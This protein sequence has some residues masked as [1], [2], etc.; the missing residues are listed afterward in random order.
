MSDIDLKIRSRDIGTLLKMIKNSNPDI[1]LAVIQK[2]YL[3]AN[4]AHEGQQRLSGEPYIVHPLEVGIILAG[5]KLDTDTI[6][7]ALLH[8]TVEDTGTTLDMI[9]KAFGEEV[10]R[11]VDS[12]TKI[13]S[14]KSRTKATAQ[15]ATLRKMLIA[16][17]KDIRVIII[18]LAD[19]LHNMRTIMFQP[20]ETQ[21]RVAKETLD[22]YAPLARRLGMSK[23]SSELEDLAFRVLDP[24]AYNEIRNNIAQRDT[25]LEE[26]LENVRMILGERLAALNI[27][28]RITGRAKHYYSIHKKIQEQEKSFEEIYDIRA[29]RIITEEIRDCYGVLGVVHTLWSPI[30]KRFKDYIAVPKSNMYQSLHTTVIGPDGHRLEVQIRTEKMHATAEMGIAAHWLYKEDPSVIRKDSRNLTFLKDITEWQTDVQD[31]REFMKSL[32]M[33]LY[34]NEIFVFSPKGKIIKL[35]KG[36][37]PIDFAYSIH[38]EIGHSTIGAKVNSQIVPLKAKLKS[39]DIVEIMTSKKGHPSES[40]LKLAIS[41]GARNRIRQWLRRQLESET[42]TDEEQEKPKDEKQPAAPAQGDDQIRLKSTPRKRQ[43]QAGITING[44]TNILIRLSQC[45]Q[46]IPGDDVVGFITRGRGIT[47]HKRNCPSL[48]RLN[49]EQERFVNI[50][51]EGSPDTFYPVKVAVEGIDRPNLLKDVADEIALAKTNIV[52]VEARVEKADHAVFRFILE[53]RSNDHLK[54]II[55]RL[56]NIKNITNVYKLNEKV[57]LK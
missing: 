7:A 18:K 54:D 46:P 36:A 23:I 55:A 42:K 32:K 34:D 37:T 24:D 49:H 31:T 43:K 38:T 53:V 22:I 45:C 41:P 19:K 11:L 8:D 5:F 50:K 20:P 14:I 21:T 39:G 25:E 16:T 56:K 26:Y 40:W 6:A 44:A 12:V 48:K 29:V 9:E 52:K 47:V 35:P 57:I 27:K 13:S 3:F 4:A 30:I 10:A 51:W 2:A 33:D 1:D 17:V 28:A 15:A